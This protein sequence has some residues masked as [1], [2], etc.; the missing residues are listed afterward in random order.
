MI[1]KDKAQSYPYAFLIKIDQCAV[2]C[3]LT[4]PMFFMAS[5]ELVDSVLFSWHFSQR[6]IGDV[7][8]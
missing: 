3:S 7:N 5:K 4:Y 6:L 1:K 2:F 8:G